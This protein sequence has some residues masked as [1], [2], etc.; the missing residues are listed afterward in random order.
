MLREKFRKE[1]DPERNELF[2]AKRVLF[3]E[4]DTEKLAL[5]AFAEKLR[6]D[7]DRAG[8]TIVEVGGKKSLKAMAEVAI[9]F[10]IP[11]GILF[12]RDSK[13][14][15]SEREKEEACNKE[16]LGLAP[17]GSIHAAWMLDKDYE[18]VVRAT[19]GEKNYI[20]LCGTY[21]TPSKP[22]KGRLIAADPRTKVPPQIDEVLAWATGT[23]SA[24]KVQ[25]TAQA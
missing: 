1:L 3:V 24:L 18:A 8:V 2:F 16:L 25:E 17:E 6:I 22:I 23:A 11:T 15:S 10:G 13:D 19:L 5:P 12:D 7:L 20:Q 4:G 21:S 9:S 14:F